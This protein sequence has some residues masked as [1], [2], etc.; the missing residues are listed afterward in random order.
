MSPRNTPNPHLRALLD[1]TGW[2]NEQL[3]RAVNAVGSLRALPLHYDRT[4]V[5]HWLLGSRPRPEVAD[6][7]C[8]VLSTA[9]RR[10]ITPQAAGLAPAPSAATVDKPTTPDIA[11]RL[12]QLGAASAVS[13][14][15]LRLIP[16]DPTLRPPTAVAPSPSPSGRTRVS[17][18]HVQA[19][20][21][22]ATVFAD[23]DD[24]FGGARTRPALATYLATD[25]APQL[26]SPAG[27]TLHRQLRQ[28]AADLAYLTA[29]TCFD[30]HLHGAAQTYYR[31]AAELAVEAADPL[32]HAIALRQMSVQAN[33][34]G[35]RAQA[36]S[37]AQAAAADV[38][39]LPPGSA[40]FITGQLAVTLAASDRRREAFAQL[41]RAQ[42]LL[43]DAQDEQRTT[44]G[45]HSA[46]L[47]HQRAEVL[48]ST[49]DVSRACAVLSH[50]LT[51]RPADERRARALTTAR[52]AEL[53]LQ[54]G[55][56]EAACQ[57][58]HTFLHDYPHLQ[59]A[60]ATAALHTM[61][62]RLRSYQRVP[63][64]AQLLRHPIHHED[65][66]LP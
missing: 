40:A 20:N 58:W 62:S 66:R 36:L 3:A 27:A 4:S 55:Q 54:Q 1:E 22:M 29:F 15:T 53:M 61:R 43:D 9:L 41:D 23:A 30:E 48:A 6:I 16:Y 8:H 2:T 34:L 28:A 35:D 63:A 26:T 59:S 65:C 12:E 37:L 31:I 25:I 46:A 51:R 39:K 52:L 44:G 17:T 57:H 42:N 60:R 50:S 13:P 33:H 24:M 11:V 10:A 38:T 49:G 56:L 21:M 47:N 14:R 45:Y 5:A 18:A 64:A 19:A 7:V 32:R